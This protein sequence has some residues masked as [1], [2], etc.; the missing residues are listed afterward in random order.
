MEAASSHVHHADCTP[1]PL[2]AGL[3]TGKERTAGGHVTGED[4]IVA[5]PWLAFAA[6]LAVLGWR[7]AAGR[8][9]RRSGPARDG[10]GGRPSQDRPDDQ[11]V[12]PR[13]GPADRGC[14]R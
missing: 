4:L 6:G 9:R 5:A 12:P 2:A 14:D 7:L 13:T 11:S 1:L 10:L 8:S 3:M